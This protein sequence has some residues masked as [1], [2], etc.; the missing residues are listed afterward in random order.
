[1]PYFDGPIDDQLVISAD[2]LG[3]LREICDSD[4]LHYQ[5]VRDLLDVERRY[6]SMARRSGL[7]EAMEKVFTKNFFDGEDDAIQRARRIATI[8]ENPLDAEL[9]LEMMGDV[10]APA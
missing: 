9:P 4:D 6:K 7:F 1:V 8:R 3:V 10:D 5:L 2:D